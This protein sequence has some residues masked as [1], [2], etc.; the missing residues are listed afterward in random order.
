MKKKLIVKAASISA[1]ATFTATLLTGAAHAQDF[2]DPEFLSGLSEN[3]MP[4]VPNW[5][6]SYDN[7]RGQSV[8]ASR[9]LEFALTQVGDEYV[10]LPSGQM[11]TGLTTN[12]ESWDCSGLT[13]RAYREAGLDWPAMP[14]YSQFASG[15]VQEIPYTEARPGDLIFFDWYQNPADTP[16]GLT[17]RAGIDH[18]ALVLDPKEGTIVEAANPSDGVQIDRYLDEN[19]NPT[20]QFIS[21]ARVIAAA[22]ESPELL[23]D[24]RFERL[25]EFASEIPTKE[26]LA[27]TVTINATEIVY[28]DTHEAPQQLQVTLKQLAF[29]AQQKGWNYKIV[30]SPR[31]TQIDFTDSERPKWE[32]SIQ[33]Q[34]ENG[35][36]VRLSM[37]TKKA[38]A[39]V[40]TTIDASEVEY[41]IDR[42]SEK[43]DRES[44]NAKRTSTRNK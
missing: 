7:S 35:R 28:P 39:V 6:E 5:K 37:L 8:L 3:V 4:G 26:E 14:S 18:V 2:T 43:K 32:M 30:R 16:R 13:W 10:A 44:V 34:T 40:Q 41:M 25:I 33:A 1:A 23:E 22:P 27:R 24:P 12:D 36:I 31:L 38:R 11:N 21:V 42:S 9:A 17:G 29:V 15:Y 20:P 19:G